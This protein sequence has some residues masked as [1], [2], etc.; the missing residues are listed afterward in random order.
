MSA[1]PRCLWRECPPV[2]AGRSGTGGFLAEGAG[3]Y[4]VSGHLGRRSRQTGQKL[5]LAC[6]GHPDEHLLGPAPSFLRAKG[7]GP[8]GVALG[9][10]QLFH[11]P[12]QSCPL[13]GPEVVGPL[14]LGGSRH[15]LLEGSHLLRRGF[16]AAEPALSLMVF[17][18]RLAGIPP[19]V[20]YQDGPQPCGCFENIAGWLH[21]VKHRQW[22]LASYRTHVL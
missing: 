19:P 9:F 1:C 13:V 21:S 15:H 17:G 14:M 3:W 11:E 20:S 18:G 4:R 2:G 22:A 16:C 8:R 12:C 7:W 5:R 10:H 6:V